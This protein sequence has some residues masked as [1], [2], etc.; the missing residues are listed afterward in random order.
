MFIDDNVFFDYFYNNRRKIN[1]EL[2]YKQLGSLQRHTS[3]EFDNLNQNLPQMTYEINEAYTWEENSRLFD[4]AIEEN[5]NIYYAEGL[6]ER[7]KQNDKLNQLY[8]DLD[9]VVDET[10]NIVNDFAKPIEV[11]P[12]GESQ[13]PVDAGIAIEAD[14]LDATI[15]ANDRDFLADK[16]EDRIMGE[17]NP[18]AYAP[19]Q[20]YEI[21]KKE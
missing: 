1:A 12:R 8:N 6:G 20:A 18:D 4:L 14:L 5:R 15:I 7:I 19:R 9:M 10:M 3:R 11:K 21:I 13:Y 2:N 16:Q 17:I